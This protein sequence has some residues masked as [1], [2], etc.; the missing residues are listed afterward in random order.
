M[1]SREERVFAHSVDL[2]PG[3]VPDPQRHLG[4]IRDS[5]HFTKAAKWLESIGAKTVLDVGSYDGWLDFLL[6]AKGFSVVGVE[7]IEGLADAAVRY[8]NRNF[9]EYEVQMGYFL[10]IELG[11]TFDAVICFETLEHMPLDD[12]RESAKR[13][14]SLAR[15]GVMVSLPDQDHHQN[16]QHLF[17]P[18]EALIKDIWGGMPGYTLEYVPYPG[19]TI[20]ANW[21][22]SHRC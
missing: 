5:T 18:T 11:R 17:T 10:D 1:T 6:I 19:T 3:Y 16:P 9:L 8:G 13:F 12:A 21:F 20:P 4:N 14:A 7:L 22:I 2:P 15:K